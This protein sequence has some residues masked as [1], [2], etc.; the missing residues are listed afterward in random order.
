[1]DTW[2]ENEEG[3]VAEHPGI[4]LPLLAQALSLD[5]PTEAQ[6]NQSVSPRTNPTENDKPAWLLSKQ[7]HSLIVHPRVKRDLDPTYQPKVDNLLREALLQS[8]RSDPLADPTNR[9]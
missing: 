6:V 3:V 9:P 8:I 5:A 2:P 1:M 4:P 7:P